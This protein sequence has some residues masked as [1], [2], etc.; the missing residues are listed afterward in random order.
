[1]RLD[2]SAT[3]VGTVQGGVHSGFVPPSVLAM[4]GQQVGGMGDSDEDEADAMTRSALAAPGARYDFTSI[5]VFAGT[6]PDDGGRGLRGPLQH[7]RT[8]Q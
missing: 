2:A 7:P 6:G 3:G 5:R 8:K 1:M 4:P